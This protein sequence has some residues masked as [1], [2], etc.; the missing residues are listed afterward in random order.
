MLSLDIKSLYSAFSCLRCS[1]ASATD[2]SSSLIPSCNAD[3]SAASFSIEPSSS[4]MVVCESL[5]E[6]SSSFFL[7]SALSNSLLQYSFFASSPF[8]SFCKLEIISSIMA[9]TFSKPAVLPL[10]AMAI[11]SRA[12]RLEPLLRRI[13]SA[14]ARCDDAL[15]CTCMKL[16]LAL[17]N[18]FLK[19]SSASS[20]LRT[21]MVS[22]RATS[23]SALV[24]LISSHSCVFVAQ[25]SSSSCL[26]FLSAASASF[27]SS[28][29]FAHSASSTP[30]SPTRVILL[31]IWA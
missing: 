2:L 1:V 16:A 25:P 8:C 28:R 12:G 21:L 23:S 18:V 14:R 19:T 24:F 9:I 11:K 3:I 17:G 26:N 20:S 4:S 10:N 6:I 30:S 29:S 15:T 5:M 27:V 13:C 22:A 31:S 7:S